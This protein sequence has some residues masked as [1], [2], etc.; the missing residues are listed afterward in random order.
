[1]TE[2]D[3]FVIG[4]GS[5]GVRAARIAA[6]HGARVAL[7]EE[8]RVGG[9]CVI[10]GCVPKKLMVTAS[11]F[12]DEFEDG[13]NFGWTVESAR[14]DWKAFAANLHREVDRLSEAYVRGLDNAGVTIFRERAVI[15]APDRLRLVDNGRQITARNIIVA[16]GGHPNVVTD[17]PG[18]EHA[19]TSEAMFEM[20][21]LP[22]RVLIVGAGYVAIEFASILSGLGVATTLLHR[23]NEV[24]RSFDGDVSAAMR[25]AMIARGIDII[26]DDEL[27]AIDK[28]G[29][30]LTARTKAGRE[31]VVDKVLLA[32]GRSPNTSGIGLEEV[33]VSLDEDGAIRVDERSQSSVPNIYAIG[34]VTNRINLTPV[35]I[36]EGHSLADHLFGDGGEIVD[37]ENVPHA[38]FGVPEIGSVGLSEEV[39]REHFDALDIY[40][41]SFKPMRSQFAGRDEKMLMKLIVDGDTGRV[42]GCHFLG[43]NAAELIQMVAIAVKMGATKAD[44]DATLAL[45]PTAAEELVTM[46]EPTE[47]YRRQAAE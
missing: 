3:L 6:R 16:T 2:F 42:L 24:L 39:A 1:M 36:R 38:V 34:D 30:R 15:E 43:P 26:L 32:I 22:E 14:F 45:H 23:G 19:V 18:I 31:I 10:R 37:H 12:R 17:L 46:R 44:I 8:D 20:E 40:A 5:G 9:T 27:A 47:R 41:R 35:A 33:G 29:D 28:D 4:G 7:A 21:D 25:Q 11:R 13:V